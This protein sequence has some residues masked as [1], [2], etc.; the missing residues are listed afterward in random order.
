M[1]IGRLSVTS[2]NIG[3]EDLS[4]GKPFIATLRPIEFSLQDFR[5]AADFEN[6]YRFEGTTTAGEQLAWSG[7]FTLQ[8]LGS[9]GQFA[10]TGLKAT[11]IGA[12][13]QDALPF[14]LPSGTLDLKGE[15]KVTLAG[16]LGLGIELPLEL[17]LNV[18]G[19][20]HV[21]VRMVA[22]VQFHAWLK[23]PLPGEP[24]QS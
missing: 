11:T 21:A 7:E 23:A 17:G 18:V 12:Y 2:G 14:D 9:N 6:H 15:Y 3:F 16:D 10:I 5:T 20:N 19:G 22:E 13:L 24:R 8:P 4:R 1:R